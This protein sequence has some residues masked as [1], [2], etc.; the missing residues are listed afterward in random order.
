VT[1]P[2]DH[3][4]ARL[5]ECGRMNFSQDCRSSCG[6]RG[7]RGSTFAGIADLDRFL[8]VLRVG[9]EGTLIQPPAQPSDSRTAA[10][11]RRRQSLGSTGAPIDLHRQYRIW[12]DW[13]LLATTLLWLLVAIGGF[14]TPFCVAA[15]TRMV[16][17]RYRIQDASTARTS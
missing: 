15:L 3:I 2:A 11:A 6:G 14:A 17:Y 12:L 10:P 13:A 16:A 7:H 1:D 8:R 9:Q 5:A 4:D